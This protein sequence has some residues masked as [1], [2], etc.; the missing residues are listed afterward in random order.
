[1]RNPRGP[2][3]R[4]PWA[5]ALASPLAALALLA[6]ACASR[7]VVP[8]QQA[9]TTDN[10][11]TGV[12]V[13]LAHVEDRRAFQDFA[14]RALTPTLAGDD[15][16]A[17]LRARAVGRSTS[18][19]GGAGAN[20]F[21]PADSS[22]ELIAAEAVARALR[23]AGFRVLEIGDPGFEDAVPL[24]LG[25]EQLWMMRNPPAEP[26]WVEAE[27]RLRI[28]G[29][30]PGLERGAVVEVRE[31]L[32]RG[33][34][35]YGMWRQGL[36]KGLTELTEE[37]QLELES[38][39]ASLDASPL[40]RPADAA[41]REPTTASAPPAPRPSETPI[42]FGNYY[43]LA[44]GIDDYQHLPHLRTAVAD[45][46]A[47]AVLLGERYGFQTRLLL[48]ATR[49]DLIQAFSEYREKLG[50]EDNLLVYYAGHG[51]NDEQ[52]GL[53]YWLPVDAAPND[54][55]QWVSNAKITSFL[56]A[57]V[58]KH[59]MIVSDSCYSGTLTRGIEI[60]RREPGYLERL[61]ARRARLVLASG[62]NE[63]VADDGGG[64]HSVFANAFLQALEDN[65]GVLDATSLHS[66]IR[67]PV[68]RESE[69]TPQFGPIR[70][71]RHEDGD[72]LFVRVH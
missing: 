31:K 2:G 28:S 3:R 54:E 20:V 12:G 24:E 68:L 58:A 61:S 33:G 59:V 37:A 69:Q 70:R 62:G 56:R 22:V 57:M 60:R 7:P 6:L 41:R 27:I 53:G 5:R 26:A 16:D 14:G 4:N 25:V 19:T 30:L 35:S 23:A 65:Q 36:E 43:L 38:V 32:S 34:W 47:V 51:W 44:I 15:G 66:Q 11:E 18:Q 67:I 10:P 8:V 52:A 39:R 71:A 55:T 9:G 21:L 46:R 42:V 72:F 50:P 17:V 29:P 49:A 1:M 63:P 64:G 48:N 40:M 13:K 45:A